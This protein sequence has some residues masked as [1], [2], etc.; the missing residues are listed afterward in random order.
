MEVFERDCLIYLG[1]AICAAGLGKPGRPCMSYT[2]HGG[3]LD[4]SG[5]LPFGEVKLFPL[6]PEQTAKISVNPAKG[7]DLGAGPG[8]KIEREV[9]GGTVG[10]IL[11]A[12]GRPLALPESRQE[13]QQTM[14]RWVKA[15]ELYPGPGSVSAAKKE[16]GS[17]LP[18]STH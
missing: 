18:T 11:D 8:R 15:L 9:R 1:T 5:E 7:F 14:A 17:L 2:V 12:R 13:A 6:G 10:L 4:Q 16:R 3:G